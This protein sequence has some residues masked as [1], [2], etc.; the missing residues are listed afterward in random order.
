MLMKAEPLITTIQTI[1]K[2]FKKNIK[3]IYLSPQGKKINQKKIIKLSHISNF[4]L[5]CGRYT[6]I[7]ERVIKSEIDEEWSIGDYIVTGGELPAMIVIDAVS[8]L[9][10]GVL[11]SPESIY[12]D[13][14]YNGLL[15]CPQYTRPLIIGN[16]FVPPILLSGHHSKIKTWKIKKSLKQ[17]WK[18][19]PDILKKLK[20]TVE[21]KKILSTLKNKE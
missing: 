17:T 3:V 15:N 21:Q 19:R 2:L 8:R 4:I 7:D 5:V 16:M 11:G 10:P 20:L 1:K 14:F 9:I 13:S 6:G 12:E 18:K